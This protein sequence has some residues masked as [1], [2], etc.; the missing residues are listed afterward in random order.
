[1]PPILPCDTCADTRTYRTEADEQ[2]RYY[3]KTQLSVFGAC[4]LS[5][6]ID[7]GNALTMAQPPEGQRN[8]APFGYRTSEDN[9]Q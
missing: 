8:D 1:M 9:A 6:A 5:K 2:S 4:S 7:L 3:D